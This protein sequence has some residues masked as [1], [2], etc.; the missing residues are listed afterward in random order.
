MSGSFKDKVVVVTGAG[1]GI[2]RTSAMDFAAAGALVIAAG[3][4]EEDVQET[5]ALA[6]SAG[7]N[8]EAAQVDVSDVESVA[9]FFSNIESRHKCLDVLVNCAGVS[10]QP[11]ARLGDVTEADWARVLGVN[12]TGTWL[13]LK[14]AVALMETSGS[15]SIVNVASIAG[16]R[17]VPGQSA[18]AVSKHAVIGITKCAAVDYAPSGIRVNAVCPGGIDTPMLR[19]TLE[20]M[21]EQEAAGALEA[22]AGFHPLN[23]LGTA[24]DISAAMQFLS[25]DE[26][27]FIT[28]AIL[29]ADGGWGAN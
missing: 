7:G 3:N 21:S 19:A 9:S 29:T 26:A 24:D 1:S 2:G 18:Y 27:S 14:H 15:G 16:L 11:A 13:C 10:Q 20:G 28:G 4:V 22:M 8:C 25:S 17:P 5:A 6:V 12:T 23:R